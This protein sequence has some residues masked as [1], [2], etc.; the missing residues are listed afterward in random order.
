[1]KRREHARAVTKADGAASKSEA[2]Q[3][4]KTPKD[5]SPPPPSTPIIVNAAEDAAEMIPAENAVQVKSVM[6]AVV[7]EQNSTSNPSTEQ[8]PAGA[9]PP[10]LP[11][12][13]DGQLPHPSQHLPPPL[14]PIGL[15]FKSFRFQASDS[16]PLLPSL[17]SPRRGRGVMALG[18]S[19]SLAILLR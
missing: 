17:T 13:Q 19:G 4:D 12:D 3:A 16:P 11:E 6:E 14:S 10:H 8:D 18:Q 1:M 15:A 7:A 5:D 2:E 9:L